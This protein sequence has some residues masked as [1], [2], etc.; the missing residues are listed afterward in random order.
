M[1]SASARSRRLAAGVRYRGKRYDRLI[2]VRWPRGAR[3]WELF[4]LVA[5]ELAC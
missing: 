3:A 1:P 4:E 2:E 5:R